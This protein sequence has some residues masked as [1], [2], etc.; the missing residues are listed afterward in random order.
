VLAP[1]LL[2]PPAA[3]AAWIPDVVA[4]LHIPGRFLNALKGRPVRGPSWFGVSCR[5][6][7]E[8]KVA[9]TMGAD[10]AFL[11]PV[12]P[13]ASHPGEPA[14]GWEKFGES[15]EN[16]PLPVYAIGGLG[17]E[18]LEDAWAAGAQGIAAIRSLWP[19]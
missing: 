19:C 3:L 6:T 11:G 18:D 1:V 8:L 2:A 12:K 7:H 5:D 16:L 17:P 14:I 13:T 4:G 10:Y 15:I 9:A